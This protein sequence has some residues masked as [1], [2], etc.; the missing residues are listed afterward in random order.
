MA[1]ADER[2]GGNLRRF[3]EGADMAQSELARRMS[4]AGHAWQQ[5]TVARAEAGTQPLRAGELETL[6]AMFHVPVDRFFWLAGEA[7]EQAITEGAIVRLREAGR[8]AAGALAR[9]HAAREAAKRA[10][11]DADGSKHPRVRETAE[12]VRAERADVTVTNVLAEARALWD[13]ERS[14]Q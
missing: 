5:S 11:H 6:A 13:K 3:R 8:E 10:A 12:A 14:G 4:A 9:L 2:A 7:A 1:T